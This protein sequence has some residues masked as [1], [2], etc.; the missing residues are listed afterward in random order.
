MRGYDDLEIIM[1][2]FKRLVNISFTM[3]DLE[4]ITE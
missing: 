2:Y 4:I 1:F 3:F